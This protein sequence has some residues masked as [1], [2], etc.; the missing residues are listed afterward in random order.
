MCLGHSSISFTLCGTDK[1]LGFFFCFF[2]WA[3][4]EQNRLDSTLLVGTLVVPCSCHIDLPVAFIVL[5]YLMFHLYIL[6]FNS[7]LGSQA[8]I[9]H[10]VRVSLWFVSLVTSSQFVRPRG[11]TSP[12]LP[13]QAKR[14]PQS[15]SSPNQAKTLSLSLED[16]W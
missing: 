14:N 11:E 6:V 12:H 3:K 7:T 16:G 4:Q 2:L 8:A 15:L 10:C 1:H 9:L 5:S 13:V